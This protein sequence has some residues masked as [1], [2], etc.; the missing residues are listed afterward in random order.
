MAPEHLNSLHTAFHTAKLKGVHKN[1]TPSPKSFASEL[2]GLLTRKTKL[3]W[4]YHSK[5]SRVLTC[6]LCQIM[7]TLPSK[8]GLW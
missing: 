8:N 4:K 5:R 3:E 7:Y 6:E 2:L 1:M